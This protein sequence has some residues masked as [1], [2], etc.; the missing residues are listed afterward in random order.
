MPG[1]IEVRGTRLPDFVKWLRAAPPGGIIFTGSTDNWSIKDHLLEI[2]WLALVARENPALDLNQVLHRAAE[3]PLPEVDA[4]WKDILEGTIGE[5]EL[6]R[7]VQ[8]F[9]SRKSSIYLQAADNLIEFR[10]YN[11]FVWH[12]WILFDDLWAS[13]HPVLARSLRPFCMPISG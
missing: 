4:H 2:D 3:V 1:P 7:S 10:F 8:Q 5:D 12:T 6:R 13:A 9:S 11:G